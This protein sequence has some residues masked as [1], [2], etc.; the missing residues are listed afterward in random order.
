MKAKDYAELKV[1]QY[2]KNNT[3]EKYGMYRA[4]QQCNFD[5]FDLR[6][7]FEAGWDEALKSQFRKC[8]DNKPQKGEEPKD[9]ENV[10]LL[11]QIVGGSND[12]YIF[13]KA[14]TYKNCD[15]EGKMLMRY[16]VI[17]WMPIPSFDN[18]LENNK[19]VLKRLKDK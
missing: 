5:G 17:A 13:P 6:D 19:D 12:G 18:I 14:N 4:M 11:C 1:K 2:D 7:A 16:N 10:I 3:I 15:W 9:G 8:I